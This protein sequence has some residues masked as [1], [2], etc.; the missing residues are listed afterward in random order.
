[1]SVE[2][3]NET[4]NMIKE[5][6]IILPNKEKVKGTNAGS[7]Q[8]FNNLLKKS[9]DDPEKFW[10][11]VANELS[12][13]HPWSKTMEGEFPDFRFFSGGITNPAFNMLD[14]NI[15]KGYANKLA[16]IWEGE[17]YDTKF[18]TYK[19]LLCEVNKFCNVLK[20]FG[21]KKGDRV[22]IYL[23]NLAETVI[24]VLACYRM[25][26]L[27]NTVFSGFSANALRER[28]NH[29]EP[30]VFITADGIYRRGRVIGLKEKADIAIEGIKSIKASIIIKR[31]DNPV[32]MKAGRD[33]WWD[34]LMKKSDSEFQPEF[35]EANEP[36]L[37]FY[38]SGTTG[39][40]KGVV[41]SGNA[42]VI[43]NYIYA[44]YH[45]DLHQDDVFWCM[46][47]IGWLTM[48]IWGIVGALSNGITTIFYEGSIDYPE[49]DRVYQILEKYRVNKWWTS[50]TATR[51]LM[52]FGEEKF[53]PYDLS[54]LDVVA[55]VG[56]PLNPE[57]WKWVYEKIG[58]GKI[59]LN[60]TYGQTET[61]GC[62]L[63]GAAWLTPMKAG[64]CGIQFLGAHLDI[65]D[66][67][68]NSVPPMVV[69]NLIFNKPIPM[70]IRDLWKDH[71]R[72]LD[73]YFYKVPGVYYTY[74]AAVRDNDG[75]IW[76]LSRT[77]DVI[78]VSGHRISTMEIESAVMEVEGVVES[79]VIGTPDEV[80]GMVPVVFVTV[81][82]ECDEEKVKLKI[83]EKIIEKIGKIAL[84]GD[85][86]CVPTTP[87]TPSG[88]IMRRFLRELVIKGKIV[89]DTTSLE[90]P[91]SIEIISKIISGI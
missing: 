14:R 38:T 33:H 17:N 42:F 52:K 2:A 78:N 79:A 24:A 60:N 45:L 30:H 35:I 32:S 7:I 16:L 69:G 34:E 80:K 13:F 44:K 85:I 55:F 90:N 81:R 73:T 48:H 22:S 31:A 8:D 64:S 66:D 27:F 11:D 57:A 20:N 19:M 4:L 56:E 49:Q 59:Y 10:E 88:K 91:D 36:G 89:S 86:F 40:P 47:D 23:P 82:E 25:G 12:W 6:K 39:K 87:K 62:P 43:N 54:S 37:V 1:M 21:L 75:H 50:P 63:A 41:H 3:K 29:F 15:E 28:L 84:P 65:V 83:T 70:L 68:G 61:A 77:D 58:K 18:F 72:Y 51:M 67:L 74:D 53:Q 9:W 46:A 71:E 26:V 5:S 76:V